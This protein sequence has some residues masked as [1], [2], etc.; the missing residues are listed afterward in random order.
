MMYLYNGVELP[1]LPEWDKE[2]YP[3]AYL[4]YGVNDGIYFSVG[5]HTLICFDKPLTRYD[6][7]ALPQGNG[8]VRYK[9]V[10]GAFVLLGEYQSGSLLSITDTYATAI[11]SNKDFLYSDGT[12]YLKA[13]EPVPVETPV[14]KNIN[15]SWVKQTAYKVIGGEWVLISEGE[16]VPIAYSY[17]GVVLPKLPEWDRERYPYAVI[18][19]GMNSAS[20]GYRLY[21]TTTRP[22]AKQGDTMIHI[23][24]M[25]VYFKYF[26]K[27]QDG[28]YGEWIDDGTS[29][30]EDGEFFPIYDAVG[31]TIW[32]NTDILNEDG[33]VYL[34]ASYPVPVYE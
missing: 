23:T 24:A 10:N 22:F 31:G 2:T 26:S 4:Y 25:G 17:N 29:E 13:S 5:E 1:Q 6:G 30:I 3:Y 27:I 12:L 18:G 14:Y 19:G 21:L 34:A 8:F 28:I 15:G 7:Y 33:T 9:S 32:T 16:K 20:R 11:W